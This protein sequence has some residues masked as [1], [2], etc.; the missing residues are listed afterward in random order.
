LNLYEYVGSALYRA[1]ADLYWKSYR[2][3]P[4]N[5][6]NEEVA[7]SK[8]FDQYRD[9]VAADIS[10]ATNN[11]YLQSQGAPD[12]TRS[13]GLVVDLAVAYFRQKSD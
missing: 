1:N 7:Y 3:L 6:I 10:Q 5:V 12:G 11:F 8:F 13:Y 2:A 9:N 4:Q